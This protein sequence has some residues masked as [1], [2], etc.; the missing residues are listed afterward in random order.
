MTQPGWTIAA[1]RGVRRALALTTVLTAVVSG[2]LLAPVAALA[3]G[4]V[5]VGPEGLAD[6]VRKAVDGDTIEL[7]PGEYPGGLVIEKRQLTL[8][9]LGPQPLLVKGQGKLPPER[10]LWTVR[11]GVVTI[12][13]LEF[14]GARATDGSG[15]G[16]RHEG[17]KLTLRQCQFF[18]NEHGVLSTN[19]EA[20]ELRIESSVIGMAPRVAGGLYHLLNIGRIGKLTI[21]GSR[22]QQ[23]FE[24]HM[25]KTRARD[26]E[27][28]YNFIHDG[29]RG[30]ASHAIDVA[31][32]GVAYIV[33]NVIGRG[34]DGQSLALVK[35]GAEGRIWDK[36]ELILAHNTLMNH[37]WLPAWFLRIAR[38][39]LPNDVPV[40]AINNLI[41]GPGIFWLGA[42]GHFDGNR[43]ALRSM[44][45]DADT[46][47]FELPPSS[48]WRGS[49]VDPRKIDGRDL[50]PKAEFKWPV[51]T[52]PLAPGR[53]QWAPGAFQR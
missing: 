47:A 33:G 26:N 48:I 7:L 28:T 50:S 10:G 17:G 20:A 16:V 5:T 4:K 41:V 46:S 6:A 49:G 34:A 11:G 32:G 40:L 39:S 9:G 24:G 52:E 1:A 45:V 25:I 38:D 22:V 12:E 18:D 53:A 51:G 29:Q 21:S 31:G 44:L 30:G 37:G 14:R 3:A 43:H 23:G 42:S 19:D 15:A 8:R 36:N 2:L 35:Y 13:N 27:I